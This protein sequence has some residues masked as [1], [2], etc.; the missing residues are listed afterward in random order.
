MNLINPWVRNIIYNISIGVDRCRC[1]SVIK[2]YN[3]YF[4]THLVVRPIKGYI[5]TYKTYEGSKARIVMTVFKGRPF[6][7]TQYITGWRS[8]VKVD[9]SRTRVIYSLT[10]DRQPVICWATNP[11]LT[12]LCFD[13]NTQVTTERHMYPSDVFRF[14]QLHEK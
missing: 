14:S 9:L 8:V 11:L 3:I 2:T 10:T 6:T 5:N 7:I 12:R 13:S 4:C 1:I